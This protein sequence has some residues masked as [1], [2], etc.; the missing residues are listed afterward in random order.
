MFRRG[1]RVEEK[2][3][4]IEAEIAA[5]AELQMVRE[6]EAEAREAMIENKRLCSKLNYSHRQIMFAKAPQ[7]GLKFEFD[8]QDRSNS[9][10]AKMFAQYGKASGV[11][12][13]VAW[14]TREEIENQREYERVLYDGLTIQETMEQIQ[15]QEEAK[16]KEITDREAELD[17][18]LKAMEKELKEWQRRVESRNKAAEKERSQRQQILDE[19]MIWF[20]SLL[21]MFIMILFAAS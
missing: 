14:P 8:E 7:V 4:E 21:L 10:K 20:W 6:A 19:V 15:Q 1:K 12:P 3:A 9:A 13:T 11:S 16:I 18:K 5:K 17:A 2:E